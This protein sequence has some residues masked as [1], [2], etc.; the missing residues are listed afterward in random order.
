MSS[1]YV[2]TGILKDWVDKMRPTGYP[3]V[4]PGGEISKLRSD[5]ESAMATIKRVNIERVHL[6][7]EIAAAKATIEE[8]KAKIV[9]I[10]AARR[11]DVMPS[12]DDD[13]LIGPMIQE[14]YKEGVIE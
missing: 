2:P 1:P 4:T 11:P 3:I 12:F 14:T 8:L 6:N 5:L 13:I 10:L 7:R 9:E